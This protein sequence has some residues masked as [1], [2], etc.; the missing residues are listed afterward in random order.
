VLVTGEGRNIPFA[1]YVLE[2]LALVESASDR[3]ANDKFHRA[4]EVGAAS[5]AV[6]HRSAL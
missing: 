4:A 1:E 3:N 5:L 2:K 6:V